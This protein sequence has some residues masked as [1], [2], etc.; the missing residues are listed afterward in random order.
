[1]LFIASL[2]PAMLLPRK[3]V[4]KSPKHLSE[5][6]ETRMSEARRGHTRFDLEDSTSDDKTPRNFSTNQ[7]IFRFKINPCLKCPSQI[8]AAYM[9]R[10]WVPIAVLMLFVVGK[11]LIKIGR[12][13]YNVTDVWFWWA[14]RHEEGKHDVAKRVP[15]IEV[16]VPSV[17]TLL[18]FCVFQALVHLV[19]VKTGQS[20]LQFS[21][22]SSQILFLIPTL[23]SFCCLFE[24]LAANL[25]IIMR[26]KSTVE[27][28]CLMFSAIPSSMVSHYTMWHCLCRHVGRFF[29]SAADDDK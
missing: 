12:Q 19:C 23:P 1:M 27:C 29:R 18:A 8:S 9:C 22:Q 11:Q 10:D 28:Q 3:I 13:H 21:P 4:G 16:G 6:R 24:F 26:G 14:G 15:M 7:I 17:L 20:T 2:L 5:R 25:P